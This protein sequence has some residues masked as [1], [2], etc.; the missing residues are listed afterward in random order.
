MIRD[1]S[2]A[3]T[4]HADC[5]EAKAL[6]GTRSY[7]SSVTPGFLMSLAIPGNDGTTRLRSGASRASLRSVPS[8]ALTTTRPATSS[9]RS[10]AR[11]RASVPPIDRPMTKT[12]AQRS[13]SASKERSTS[14]YQSSKRVAF[15]SCQRVPWPGRRGASTLSPAA[16]RCSAH[17]RTLC[18]EPVNPWLSSTPT[19]PPGR[20]A[21]SA[22]GS[23]GAGG[24]EA[25]TTGSRRR[26]TERR[27]RGRAGAQ[28]WSHADP[29]RV[30]CPAVLVEAAPPDRC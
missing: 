17:G 27:R 3:T 22:P 8:E 4:G 23:T 12:V 20:S 30:P 21:C 1:R 18:G 29:A 19:G 5:S 9:A 16:C 11:R 7:A 6:S 25:G 15:M 28:A 10:S 2:R 26:G 24:A 14:A 13:R